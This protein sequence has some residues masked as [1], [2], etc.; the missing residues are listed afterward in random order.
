MAWYEVRDPA[1]LAMMEDAH[2][3]PATFASWREKANRR[4]LALKGQGH[5]VVKGHD[6]AWQV[7]GPGAQSRGLR[8]T[9]NARKLFAA[10]R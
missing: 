9:A 3:L 4:E 2:C 7:P 6:L 5:D 8:L 1:I 10:A